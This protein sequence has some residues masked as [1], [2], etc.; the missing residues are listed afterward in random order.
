MWNDQPYPVSDGDSINITIN[1]GTNKIAAAV[2]IAEQEPNQVKVFFTVRKAGQYNINISIGSI[3]IRGSPFI[4][5]FAP[6]PPDVSKTLLVRPSSIVVC[7]VGQDYQLLLEPKDEYGNF[8]SW[9]RDPKKIEGFS[10]E[11]SSIRSN[12]TV[13][14]FV[15]WH[16]IEILRRLILHVTFEE[17]GIYQAQ[18]KLNNSLINKGDFSMIVLSRKDAQLVD[19]AIH[20]RSPTY[21]IKLI[22]LN[23]EIFSKIKKSYC[24]ISPKQ[25]ALK[26][27]FLGIIPKRLATFRL[28]P[29]TKVCRHLFK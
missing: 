17:E 28:C 23:G 13:N 4:K 15:H 29:A 10:I 12:E 1:Q 7:T 27:Y 11:C 9:G 6:G 18:I 24:A 26:D 21:E 2:Q 8:C 20:T 19:S 3:P 25:V 14:P 5:N 22:S 16:W